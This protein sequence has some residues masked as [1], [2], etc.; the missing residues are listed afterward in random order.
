M[1]KVAPTSLACGLQTT[2]TLPICTVVRIAAI[3]CQELPVLLRTAVLIGSVA[4]AAACQ[5]TTPTEPPPG[6]PGGEDPS[7]RPPSEAP[8]SPGTHTS[9]NTPEQETPNSSTSTPSGDALEPYDVPAPE[10]LARERSTRSGRALPPISGGTLASISD[11]RLV[12]ADPDRD[13]VLVIDLVAGSARSVPLQPG[14]EP[15]RVVVHGARAYV[16]LRGAGALITL[17]VETATVAART[18]VCSAPRGVVH[19]A[20]RSRVLVACARGELVSVSEDGA[21][22]ISSAFIESDLRDVGVDDSGVWLTLFRSPTLLRLDANDAVVSRRTPADVRV[23][24]PFQSITNAFSPT[25]AFRTV[26]PAGGA[27]LMLHQRAQVGLI[28]VQNFESYGSGGVTGSFCEGGILHTTLTRFDAEMPAPLPALPQAVLPVD[29]S[30][31]PD[32]RLLAA[33]APGNFA[34]QDIKEVASF[35]AGPG[36][37]LGAAQQLYL[38]S[39][40][41]L[42]ARTQSDTSGSVLL[43][44][45][46]QD[47]LQDAPRWEHRFPGEAI[48]VQFLAD[49]SFAVQVRN[50]AEL[51]VFRLDA[52]GAPRLA[53]LIDLGG[54]SVTDTGHQVFHQ[55]SGVGISCASCH[56][57]GLDDGHAWQFS[58]VGV[59]RTQALRGDVVATAPFHWAGEFA[60]FEALTD[61]IFGRR[62]GGGDLG[63]EWRGALQTWLGTLPP[64]PPAARDAQAAARGRVL[65]ESAD[66]QCA[67]CHAGEALRSEGRHDVGTGGAFEVPS[68]RGAGLRLPLMHTGCAT[69]L[70]AR[71]DPVCGG[72]DAHG[73]T[74]HL[75]A[76]EIDDLV[77]YLESL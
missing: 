45:G 13:R 17:E 64:L 23:N 30:L 68:L 71:F 29:L 1:G 50:P 8:P 73:R 31:S 52:G 53:A 26:Q 75:D 60:S 54:E 6:D 70:R 18:A 9:A 36:S 33:V 28:P 66:A 74:S 24:V 59:R 38:V 67:S 5:T 55:N 15:G 62:M 4:M 21:N 25:L 32:V 46:D 19:D 58:D 47:C 35:G 16:A 51:H 77:A 12:A 61:E 57:E 11:T 72:G 22:L 40:D 27:P 37:P 2:D 48:A 65:F 3:L 34:R 20:E 7:A 56:G 76:A 63:A 43:E 49:D 69:T 39:T 42:R 41:R 14:D 44:D 10:H